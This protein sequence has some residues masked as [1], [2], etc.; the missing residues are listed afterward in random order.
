MNRANKSG[1]RGVSRKRSGF[2]AFIGFEGKKL[3]LGSFSDPEEAARAYDS[4]ARRLFGES[5]KVNFPKHLD[6]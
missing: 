1:Y 4:E 3:Y 2:A 5:A 6:F